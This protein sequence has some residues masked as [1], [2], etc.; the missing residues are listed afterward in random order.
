[1]IS[2]PHQLI[3]VKNSLSMGRASILYR[4]LYS[5]ADSMGHGGTCPPLLQMTGHGG[6][7]EYENSKQE[8]D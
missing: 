3:P 4:I 1:M 8:T 6:H 5:G 7:R 2:L